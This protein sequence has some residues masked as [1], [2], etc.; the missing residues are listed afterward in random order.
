MVVEKSA[1]GLNTDCPTC[2]TP[3][4]V[5]PVAPVTEPDKVETTVAQPEPAAK[6]EAQT[7]TAPSKA[8]S[9]QDIEAELAEARAEIARQHTL[10][11]KAVEECE[12]LNANATHIQAELKSFQVDR[13]QL[14]AD[15]AQSRQAVTTAETRISELVDAFSALQ[16]EHGAFKYQAEIDVNA[17]HE[18]LSGAE[19]QLAAREEELREHKEVHT[20]ALR[21]LARTRAEFTKV[22]TEVISLR[23]EAAKLRTDFET[24]GQEL[25]ASRH[26]LHETQTT[27]EALTAEHEQ[28]TTE[29]EDWRKQAE[30][31]HH[32]LETL[33]TGRDLL[34]LRGQHAELQKKHQSLEITLAEQIE[35]AK[36]ENDVLR[37]IVERQN[38]TLD[39]HHHELRR[40]RRGRFAM[41]LVYGLFS[42]GMLGLGY[43]AFYVIAPQE[44]I[45]VVSHAMSQVFGH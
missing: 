43:L 26:Q 10:F 12:R 11:K 4:T 1:A 8:A 7:G 6:V 25:V 15:L 19:A 28:A 5:P 14:K 16:Q 42:L 13:Q 24:A 27:L 35:H 33:D 41:R 31:L 2:N 40:L 34:E 44:V 21:S 3:M 37:G 22:N 23:S 39:S 30:G 17:L 45:K 9:P 36:K 18:R 32:D 29:R 38:V 20:D